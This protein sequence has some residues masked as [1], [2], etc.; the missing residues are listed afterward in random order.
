MLSGMSV[1]G[2]AGID[3]SDAVAALK[4]PKGGGFQTMGLAKDEL[5]S[6]LNMGFSVP[7]PIQRKTI[8]PLLQGS[9]V[10][11]MARTGSGKTAAFAI[12][13]IHRLKE[14][15]T[16]VGIRGIVMAPTRELSLQIMRQ[17]Q[18]LS[19][20][21]NLRYCALVGGGS[22]DDQFARLAENPDIVVATPGRLLH[23][24]E[25][26]RLQLSVVA[27]VVLDEAD[28]LF[29]LGLQPQ[30]VAVLQ[31]IPDECQRALFSATM[32]SI[33]AEFTE[34]KLHN[35]VVIRLDTE[36]TLSDTLKQSSYFVRTDEKVPALLFIL[37]KVLKVDAKT[38]QA[39]VFV[40]SRYHV[41][42]LTALLRDFE[43]TAVGV[44][45]HMDQ[46]AR[47]VS[48]DSFARRRSSV[49]IVTDVAARG[50]DLPLL[51]NV[52]N[53]SFPPLPKVFIHRVGRVARAGRSGEAHSLLTYDDMPYYV[54][55]MKFLGR[56]M[57]T[58][59]DADAPT[60][61]LF[62]ADDG[63]YG[64][65]PEAMLQHEADCAARVIEVSEDLKGAQRIADR[66]HHKYTRTKKRATHGGIREA[67]ADQALR[68]DN[69]P[70]HPRFATADAAKAIAHEAAVKDLRRFK[71]SETWLDMIH[72]G[73]VFSIKPKTTLQSM[74]RDAAAEA[75]AAADDEARNVDA[76]A[77]A[78]AASHAAVPRT[79]G[80]LAERLLQRAQASKAAPP[81]TGV[82][83][84]VAPA[85][86]A[87]EYRD[88]EFFM[89]NQLEATQNDAHFS[90][91]DAAV[92]FIPESAEEAHKQR[93]VFTWNAR[94]S[95][96]VKMH[97][98]DAKALMKGM[99]N[100][101]GKKIDFKSKLD[102][103]AKW[104]KSSNLRIQD[105]GEPEDSAALARAKALVQQRDGGDDDLGDIDPD[106]DP[107][108]GKKLK[109]GRKMKRLPKDGRVRTFDEL[110]KIRQDKEKDKAKQ[111]RKD[112]KRQGR[113]GKKRSK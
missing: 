94:K 35:P 22:I 20:H 41:D 24:C 6:V 79:T 57:Q 96:Y 8:P 29:E 106:A 111:A 101:A 92:D 2:V 87:E 9:D 78:P 90:V 49:M 17:M 36:M 109:I 7:T 112:A 16:T 42:Y 67:R 110:H 100:E 26:A 64:R 46:E 97:V 45:G 43:M 105:V 81:P 108:N 21:S 61:L 34:A 70:L 50:I 37:R 19:K 66:A 58:M 10:V 102:A 95:K 71:A 39:L 88:R 104:T 47:R 62:R 63:C 55:L 53:F 80:T 75:V 93:S 84:A 73:R 72:G 74:R 12:P 113:G 68:L 77:A 25:E 52:V 99:K 40:E 4:K 89:P 44:H 31:R 1:T 56:P 83:R 33:L 23:I 85:P 28:R 98:N 32:P 13:M 11:G 51:D 15:S 103:Y 59:P 60:D 48:V 38:A 82:P 107:N 18:K 54:D 14:H 65:L 69:I 27:S 30:I 3:T 5:K 91:R 86:N 76:A